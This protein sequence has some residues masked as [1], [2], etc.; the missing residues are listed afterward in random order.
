MA[1][2]GD[3]WTVFADGVVPG[4][5]P[6]ETLADVADR[7]DRVL[8]RVEP[9][10]HGDDVLLVGHGHAL[11]VLTAVYLGRDPRSRGEPPPGPGDPLRPA[12]TSTRCAVRR[13]TRRPLTARAPGR[14]QGNGQVCTG[15]LT[16]ICSA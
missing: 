8:P 3:R 10:L 16:A 12:G 11:R 2:R 9:A 14:G 6:G 7:A 13:G 5:T 15:A 1:R 4:A